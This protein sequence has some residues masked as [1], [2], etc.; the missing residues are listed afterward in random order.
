MHSGKMV[1]Q[2][3]RPARDRDAALGVD[4]DRGPLD[5]ILGDQGSECQDVGR[6]VTARV[7]DERSREDLVAEQLGQTADGVSQTGP[8]GVLM[9]VPV[10]I[11]LGVGQS[12]V[13][14]QI[15]V[16]S[17]DTILNCRVAGKHCY[18]PAPL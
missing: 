9:S 18:F 12:I 1:F 17:G 11:D 3:G 7:G 4:D 6:R 16:S 5:Q 2:L 8:I 10:G 13:G 14:A 15:D